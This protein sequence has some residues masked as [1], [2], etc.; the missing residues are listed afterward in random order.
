MA[1]SLLTLYNGVPTVATVQ[2]VWSAMLYVVIANWVEFLI[3]IT[4]PFPKYTSLSPE[5]NVPEAAF[6]SAV[7][8]VIVVPEKVS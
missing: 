4:V 3:R 6:D 1:V 8:T 7:F 2:L 5:D